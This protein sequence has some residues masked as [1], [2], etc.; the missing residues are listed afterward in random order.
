M[1]TESNLPSNFSF[2]AL[3]VLFFGAVGGYQWLHAR[4]H[5]KWWLGAAAVTLAVTLVRPRWLTP[6]NRI[7]MGFA[8]FLHSL[9]SPIAL[10]LLYFGLFTPTGYAMRLF[11]RDVLN[12]RF[13]PSAR[14]YWVQRSPPGPEAGGLVDQF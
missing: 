8:D 3:F 12:R 13:D 10:G 11:G 9:F 14:T 1:K 6:F 4:G 5:G 7:W 2:G